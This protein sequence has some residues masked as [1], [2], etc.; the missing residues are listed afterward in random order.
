MWADRLKDW[1]MGEFAA[2]ILEA[3]GPINL[4]GAQLVYISQPVLDD[5]FPAEHLNALANLLEEPGQT[6]V[7]VN[8]LREV[9]E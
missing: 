7:F 3:L 2:S 1:G 9:D 6:K 8:V 5:I 4:V